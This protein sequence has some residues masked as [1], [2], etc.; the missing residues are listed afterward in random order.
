MNLINEFIQYLLSQKKLP[1]RIT[2]KN[3]KADVSQFIRWYSEKFQ[4]EF[5]P[6]AISN[7][8]LSAYKKDKISLGI[9]P[10]SFERHLS[11]LRKFFLFLK[12]EGHISHSPFEQQ[13]QSAEVLAKEDPFKIRDFKNFLYVYNA[14]KLTI[15]NYVIDIKQFFDWAQEVTGAKDAWQVEDK[16]VFNKLNNNVIQEY[17]NRLVAQGFSPLTVNRKLS[18]LRKYLTWA[19]QEGLI[20]TIKPSAYEQISNLKTLS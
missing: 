20:S 3:Y 13:A 18:S 11:S 10:R 4:R 17:K 16:N 2:V 19:Q 6:T 1:S 15:K 5:D 8:I 7:Q 12:L 9:A 14:S